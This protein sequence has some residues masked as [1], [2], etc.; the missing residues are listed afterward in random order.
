MAVR[1]ANQAQN[2]AGRQAVLQCLLKKGGR[3]AVCV[4][5]RIIILHMR[6]IEPE[7]VGGEQHDIHAASG[8]C[9]VRCR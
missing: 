9:G 8:S 4:C 5:E 3:V 1:C 2:A 6:D 7:T